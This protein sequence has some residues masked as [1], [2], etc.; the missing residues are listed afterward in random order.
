[1]R[2]EPL[3]SSLGLPHTYEYNNIYMCV[4]FILDLLSLFA[5]L[6]SVPAL[7]SHHLLKLLPGK[8]RAQIFI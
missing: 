2:I 8:Y 5:R 7:A 3:Y 6:Q 1:M 4:I